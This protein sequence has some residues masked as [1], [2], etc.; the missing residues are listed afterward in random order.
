ME[1]IGHMSGG[2]LRSTLAEVWYLVVV[3]VVI[4]LVVVC[5]LT[6]GGETAPVGE[7]AGAAALRGGV[8]APDSPV[9]AAQA[10]QRMS[11]EEKA[12][13]AIDDYQKRFAEDMRG[14]DAPAYL[15]AMGNLNKQKLRNFKEAARNY[16]L[17]INEYP[18]WNNI[19]AVYPQL[20]S[21]YDLLNDRESLRWLY[22]EMM[23]KFPPDSNE[24]KY[25]QANSDS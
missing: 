14:T 10:P 24:Y 18:D 15:F 23:E 16:E 11:E 21:C 6:M 2:V 20:M 22:R 17:L 19:A 4:S 8:T 7:T 9:A 5:K 12:K 3:L 13:T 25:A 1:R